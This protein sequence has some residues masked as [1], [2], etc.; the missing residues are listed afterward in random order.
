MSW[1]SGGGWIALTTAPLLAQEGAEV[2]L[3]EAGRVGARTSGST[4]G[5]VTPQHE[6]IYAAL[7]D[8][9]GTEVAQ[10]CAEANQAAAEQVLSDE[11]GSALGEAFAASRKQ[12]LGEQP[13]EMTRDGLAQQAKNADI[14]GTSGLAKDALESKVQRRADL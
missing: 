14:S 1:W 3:V 8:R 2:V 12:H 9:H 7:S 5:K 4:T 13:S 10:L 6:A 11:R